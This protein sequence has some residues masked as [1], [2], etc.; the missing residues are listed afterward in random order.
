M[1]A[2]E[3]ILATGLIVGAVDLVAASALNAS[4]GVPFQRTLQGVASGALG[5][6]SFDGGSKSAAI[7]LFFHF[8]IAFSATTFYF[9]ASN[10]VRVSLVH[11]AA[12]FSV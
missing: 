6:S 5:P 3:N 8:F 9:F 4:R 7:G 1:T 11:P 12:C 2:P 10:A